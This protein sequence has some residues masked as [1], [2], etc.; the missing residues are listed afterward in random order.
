MVATPGIPNGTNNGS[1]SAL[2]VARNADLVDPRNAPEDPGIIM[3]DD[4]EY[5]G[6]NDD[7]NISFDEGAND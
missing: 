6:M 3:T 2:T 1:E 4:E 7:D 5:G